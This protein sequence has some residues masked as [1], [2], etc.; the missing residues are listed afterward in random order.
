MVGHDVWIG[1]RATLLAGVT[2]GSGAVVAADAVVTRDVP[3]YAVVAGNPARVVR[4]RLPEPERERMLQLAWWDWP[5][6]V[7]TDC[8]G[9]LMGH[10]LDA[11]ERAA[12]HWT[13]EVA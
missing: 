12:A 10:D 13:G 7:V 1:F 3:P 4:Y 9:A 11:L 5:V 6:E 8:V 2:I